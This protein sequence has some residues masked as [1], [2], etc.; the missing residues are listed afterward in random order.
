M[1]K[2]IKSV[3][4][5][6]SSK[7]KSSGMT[8]IT[9]I[10]RKWLDGRDIQALKDEYELA[11]WTEEAN[12]AEKIANQNTI[13]EMIRVQEYHEAGFGHILDDRYGPHG[14]PMS[15]VFHTRQFLNQ[16]TQ[17]EIDAHQINANLDRLT[18]FALGMGGYVFLG[19]CLY[20]WL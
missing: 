5:S 16:P 11:Y 1:P 15:Q 18:A 19:I 8:D 7:P 14:P 3:K 17:D 2:K 6:R 20:L 13:D 4:K 10:E 9:P 12:K